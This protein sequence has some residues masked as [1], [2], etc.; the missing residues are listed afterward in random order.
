MINQRFQD[1]DY[2]KSEQYKTSQNLEARIALHR[3]FSTADT[4][5]M[6]WVFD[7][8]DLQSGQ[9]ILECGCGPGLLWR[10]NVARIPAGCHLTL[11]DLSEGMVAEAE[12]ALKDSGHSFAFQTADI[13]NLSFED[14]SFDVVVAN[15]M[16]YHVPDRE[17]GLA[18]VRRVLRTGGRFAAATNGS[19]H[20][21]Q[22]FALGEEV[23]PERQAELA[24]SRS[25]REAQ[26]MLS[27][28]LEN[29]ADQLASYFDQVDLFRYP[30]SLEVTEAEAI[31]TYVMSGIY[32]KEILPPE[33]ERE[34]R[35]YL[36]AKIERDGRIHITK[37][38]G[39]F[40]AS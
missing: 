32:F 30:D 20:L 21:R 24:A 16:L 18:E 35:T 28:R 31:I 15:H 14:N 26:M 5:W 25:L 36:N 17:K 1:S 19:N 2:L 6:T 40:I 27:F 23:F 7:Y 3:Q 29:G 39:L 37:E 9:A 38:T 13:Q 34:L 11:T 22:L 33:I 10:E 8:L 4:P 12:A